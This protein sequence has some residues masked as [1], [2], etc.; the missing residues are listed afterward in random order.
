MIDVAVAD[1]RSVG[2]RDATFRRKLG[3]RQPSCLRAQVQLPDLFLGGRDEQRVEAGSTVGRPGGEGLIG[4][5][6]VVADVDAAVVE[7]VPESGRLAAADRQ[8]GGGFGV[9]RAA[10]GVG[11][12]AHLGQRDRAV[13]AVDV[14]QHAAGADGGELPVVADEPY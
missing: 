1:R 9:V 2:E 13:G 12:A 10:V 14:A 5:G 8:R 11:E 3:S 4:G 7:V 6:R